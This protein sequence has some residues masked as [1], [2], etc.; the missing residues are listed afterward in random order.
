MFIYIYIYTYIH[1]YVC[2][3]R[4]ILSPSLAPF[5]LSLCPCLSTS[6]SEH[7]LRALP[8]IL[9]YASKGI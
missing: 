9:K 1:T 2:S 5:Q 4:Q 3:S 8:R 7:V 6:L